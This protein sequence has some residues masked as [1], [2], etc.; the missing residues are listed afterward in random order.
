MTRLQAKA[1]PVWCWAAI[2]CL[3]AVTVLVLLQPIWDID[4]F[5]HVKIG[6]IITTTRAIPRTD[7]FTWTRAGVP[8]TTHEWLSEVA[9]YLAFRCAGWNGVRAVGG[10][11]VL[12]GLGLLV[13][14]AWLRSRNAPAVLLIFALVLLLYIDRMRPR[15]HVLAFP[16]EIA[17]VALLFAPPDRRRILVASGLAVL[18]TNLHGGA[19]LA[20]VLA[21]AAALARRNRTA[22]VLAA[23]TILAVACNPA[24]LGIYREALAT[25]AVTQAANV[26]EWAPVWRYLQA[27]D[28][29]LH[30]VVAT[31][32]PFAA[33]AALVARAFLRPRLEAGAFA[34]ALVAAVVSASAGRHVYLVF[35]A[36]L[37]VLA[38][39]PKSRA[40][41]VSPG[42][43]RQPKRAI[44][45]VVA[46]LALG[47]CSYAYGVGA[48][49]GGLRN[50]LTN[51]RRPIRAGEFPERMADFLARAALGGRMWNSVD[52]GGYLIFRLWPGQ[53]V[54][55]DGRTTLF[56]PELHDLGHRA[57]A[58][59]AAP[60]LVPAVEADFDRLGVTMIASK[61]P[62]FPEGIWD[63]RRWIA[64]Y[65]DE[66]AEVFLRRGPGDEAAL[67]RALRAAGLDPQ[68]AQAERDL[69]AASGA[70]ALRALARPSPS[71]SDA[72]A[73]LR[74]GLL[75]VEFG[76]PEQGEPLL[77]RAEALG[78]R[79]PALGYA[80]AKCL[81]RLDRTPE[82]VA[83]A[84]RWA[85]RDRRL[86]RLAARLREVSG[87]R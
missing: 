40:F 17:F 58:A 78:S 25:R 83:L 86:D 55:M 24:G 27:P 8:W 46:S 29:T 52:W 41:A 87:D 33:L 66:Q 22:G 37:L 13:R 28:G 44:V 64:I 45:M 47:V 84:T 30:N 43:S 69:L 42:A 70:A 54:F 10:A 3:F 61:R 80:L 76:R 23:C 21:V 39:A 74:A 38:G 18:W 53:Q 5:W 34:V 26:P 48:L 2:A 20:P 68:L 50:A 79:E 72:S 19:V 51:A 9:F 62:F 36:A 71:E 11:A 77:R 75:D 35:P 49:Q 7:P 15:P 1:M 6:E 56:P 4:E 81:F 73:L 32:A 60:S 31:F 57:F 67:P 59:G 85:R 63:R 14:L 16:C 82:A 12:L 65:R